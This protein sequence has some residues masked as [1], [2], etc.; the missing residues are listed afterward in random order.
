M[1]E[2]PPPLVYKGQ[3]A[4]IFPVS[5]I[6]RPRKFDRP[7]NSTTIQE[8]RDRFLATYLNTVS[9]VKNFEHSMLYSSLDLWSY[10]FSNS[11]RD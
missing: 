1:R 6:V 8:I 10:G 9:V 2:Y 3:P 4:N 7:N 11:N 5:D